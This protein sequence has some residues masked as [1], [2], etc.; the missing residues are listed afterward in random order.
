[1][2]PQVSVISGEQMRMQRECAQQVRA[3]AER[4]QSYHIVTFGCQMNV[5]D[6]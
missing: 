4:P 6:S 3:L 2:N 1:M 5:H